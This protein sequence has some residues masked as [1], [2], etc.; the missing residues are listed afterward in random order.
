VQL[1]RSKR[2]HSS[3]RLL[4]VV[5][6]MLAYTS[7]TRAVPMLLDYQLN[8]SSSCSGS[9]RTFTCTADELDSESW[10]CEP[11]EQWLPDW[12]TSMRAECDAMASA[13]GQHGLG[14]F[15]DF[16]CGY[17]SNWA[18]FSCGFEDYTC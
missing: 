3:V 12:M 9:W 2:T 11:W 13:A 1:L 5:T 17:W 6:A 8:C 14:W 16:D 10:Q 15:H 7:P 18:S 4:F